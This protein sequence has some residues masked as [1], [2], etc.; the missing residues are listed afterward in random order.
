[1]KRFFGLVV[2]L[3]A[4]VFLAACG[5]GG[6][7]GQAAAGGNGGAGVVPPTGPPATTGGTDFVDVTA[8]SNIQYVVNYTPTYPVAELAR[9]VESMTFGG[10]A[11]GDCDLDGDVDLFITYGDRGPNRLYINQLIAGSGTPMQFL[12]RASQA[13]VANTR[14][15]RVGNDRHSGPTFADIDGD[16]DLDLFIGGLFSDPNK[17]YE[18]Q[19]DCSFVDVTAGSG[20]ANTQ[21][22]HTI[23]AAFGDY[24]LDGDLDLFLTHWGSADSG[25]IN[26]RTRHLYRN[27]SNT[28]DGLVFE[29]VSDT[30]GVAAAI[31]GA[32]AAQASDTS[33]DITL[34]A[35]FARINDDLWP[36][37]ALAADFGTAQLLLS[38]STA[39]GAFVDATN[40][41]VHSVQFGMGSALGDIDFDGDLDWFV[42]SIF[43]SGTEEGE[44][45]TGNRLFRNPGGDFSV[46]GFENITTEAGVADGG[47]GWGACFL[48]LD[49]DTDLDIYHTNGWYAEYANSFFVDDPSRAFVAD[50][51]G[52]YVDRAADLGLDD[53]HDARG[54]VCA[55]FDNDGD[56]DILQLSNDQQ[57]SAAL[58][59]NVA[60]AAGNNFLRVQ[61][62]GLPPN[63]EAAGARIFATIGS[64]SQ[65]REIMIGSNYTSQNP[66]VQVF[67]L[68]AAAAVDELRVEWPALVDST[69]GAAQPEAWQSA[70]P[71]RAG[72]RGETLFIC[73]P[74]LS[75]VPSVCAQ[76]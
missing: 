58:W 18:N 39:R 53:R 11:A 17:I 21:G 31:V 41:A 22:N 55:D 16:G 54:V 12:D 73:H 63:T 4:A 23:S 37:I 2:W 44:Q 24:D 19:G 36:D 72:G 74:E 43:G 68:G 50:G 69:G 13:G 49:N 75:P 26:G 52:A 5:G 29:D 38:D 60:A 25:P 56:V 28:V 3:I 45:P 46:E 15:D 76:P 48:D 65:M 66:T 67:G 71:V 57:N 33:K 59:E 7:G 64:R 6:G 9:E 27:I 62:I 70:A 20:L 32:R 34:A 35:S 1:L 42:T 30:S 61:L 8:A 51:T 14:L 40:D 47:W 10:V